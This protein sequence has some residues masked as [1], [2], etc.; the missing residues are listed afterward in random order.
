MKKSLRKWLPK[1]LQN[2]AGSIIFAAGVALFFDPN[3]LAPGGVSGIAIITNYF[4]PFLETGSWIMVFNIPILVAGLVVLGFRFLFSTIYSVV[5]SSLAINYIASHFEPLTN[6]LLLASVAGS[7]LVSAGIGLVFRAGGTTGGT[8][9]IVK[10]L[11]RKFKHLSTGT[12]FLITDGM[13]VLASG[14]LF[15]S[16]DLSL[17]AGIALLVSMVVLNMVLYGSDE[18]R[19]V[20]IISDRD[21][22]ISD[23]LLTDLDLGVT[24]LHGEGAYTGDRRHVMMCVMKNRALPQAREIVRDTDPKA[25]VFVTKATAVFGEG[26]KSHYEGEL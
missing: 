9:V 11:R 2:T 25:F 26:F 10:L 3:N 7:V 1:L 8:D 14:I 22:E 20:Y 23:R 5:I 19:T 18:A 15:G 24:I 6:D 16:I 4:F 21:K 13:V 17:Y 12:V